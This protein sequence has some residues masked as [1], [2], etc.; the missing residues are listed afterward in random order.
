MYLRGKLRLIAVDLRDTVM[1]GLVV[2]I[3]D[4][5]ITDRAG[6]WIIQNHTFFRGLKIGVILHVELSHMK[7]VFLASNINLSI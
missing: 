1:T 2:G 4:I 3:V 7:R 5:L 6:F